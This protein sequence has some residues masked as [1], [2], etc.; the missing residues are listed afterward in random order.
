MKKQILLIVI[1]N[2][3]RGGAETLLTGILPDLNKIYSVIIVTL[4]EEC[5]FKDHEILCEKKYSLGFNSNLSL[6]SCILKLKRIIKQ[7]PPSLIHSHLFYSSLIARICCPNDVP[8][9]YSLHNEMSKSVFNGSKIFT[10]LEKQ[11]I[12]PNHYVIAVSKTVL[13]DYEISIG[14]QKNTFVLP[15][16][17]SDEFFSELKKE[18]KPTQKRK[19]KIVAVGN[20]KKQKNYQFLIRAFQG[21]KD[22]PVTLDIYGQGANKEF[23]PLQNEIEKNNL[24]IFFKGS[25]K[26][27]YEIL[28]SYDL[29]VSS[30]T[31]E[32]FGIS[33]VEA[34]AMGLPLILSELPV[35]HE[36][37][38][39]NA[40]FFDLSSPDLFAQIIIKVLNHEI[41]LSHFSKKGIE[42]SK[43]YTK[44]K[45]LEKLFEIYPSVIKSPI[46]TIKKIHAESLVHI[47]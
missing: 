25:V 18:K 27:I 9:I 23:Q 43:R 22:F 37:S 26:N 8:L 33:V 46:K 35:F 14:R 41:D 32:G 13:K 5:D 34:M 10:F 16:Y 1:D 38:F 47:V 4:S 42:I 44:Q 24:P 20:I 11:T 45:Y 36:I 15:N 6:I 2:L 3:K 19:L 29:Y 7:N 40:M 12:K 17:V 31:H 30:S 21:L 28:P 39:E